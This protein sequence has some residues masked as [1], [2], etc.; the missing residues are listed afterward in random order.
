MICQFVLLAL[1]ALL[2]CGFTHGDA[3]GSGGLKPVVV[4]NTYAVSTP[5]SNGGVVGTPTVTCGGGACSGGNA[6][7]NCQITA[8]DPS[9]NFQITT[10]CAI[11]TT[12]NGVTNLVGVYVTQTLTV[13]ATN[14][15]GAGSAN[16]IIVNAYG[17]GSVGAVAA[18]TQFSNFFT[19]RALQSSQ[20]YSTRPPW[21][22]AGVDYAVG[23][24]TGTSFKDPS[25]A[26]LPTGCTYASNV[27]TCGSSAASPTFDSYDFSLHN[28][29]SL[30]IL[31]G[32]TGTV[33]LT[34]NYFLN[35][36]SSNTQFDL[37]TVEGG[38]SNIVMT[39]NTFDG[40]SP[41]LFH[42]ISFLQ[43]LSSGTVADS[44]NAYLRVGGHFHR[45]ATAGNVTTKY[46]YGEGMCYSPCPQHGEWDILLFTGTMA[47][48]TYNYNTFLEPS[49]VNQVAMTTTFYIS[50]GNAN[51]S[52]ITLADIQANTVAI[53]LTSGTVTVSSAAIEWGYISVVT[54]N[55]LYNYIDPT[56]AQF[57][58]LDAGGGGTRTTITYTGNINL[59]DGSPI[60][61]ANTS[62]CHGHN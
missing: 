17:D 12:A 61:N 33:T 23:Y 62:N 10:L 27:V 37:I 6:L 22:V 42:V 14:A 32:V 35:G 58:F 46:N 31:S 34:N 55:V 26:G 59:R 60:S 29:I 38:S 25:S 48:L 57:C 43:F 45:L 15:S 54:S 5:V 13:Q 20:T 53:N 36:S 4:A 51:G 2:L 9:G 18:T 28:G 30:D 24:A 8:G 47:H 3:S 1:A 21:K 41:S 11:T 7:T 50:G 49:A 52:S 39:N 19:S 56:G 44:Y 40:G 16:A